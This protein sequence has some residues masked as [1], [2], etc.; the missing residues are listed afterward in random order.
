M[1]S[2]I[3]RVHSFRS[4]KGQSYHW[5]SRYSNEEI[6][7]SPQER[8]LELIQKILPSLTESDLS[9]NL[10]KEFSRSRGSLATSLLLRDDISSLL[11]PSKTTTTPSTS[12]LPSPSPSSLDITMDNKNKLKALDKAIQQWLSYSLSLDTLELRRITFD[13]SSGHILEKVARGESVHRVRSL[14]ELKRRLYDGKRCFALFHPALHEEPLVFI[15]VGLTTELSQS[16]ASLDITKS[17]KSPTHA[18]F[19][20]VNS[21]L[22][23]LRGLDMASLLIKEVANYLSIHFP[24]IVRFSTLSPIPKFLTWLDKKGK[25]VKSTHIIPSFFSQIDPFIPLLCEYI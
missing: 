7:T 25:E 23:A 16:L 2:L 19:Y 22:S 5:I 4:F 8:K 15:H 1:K 13:S 6:F 21:P 24:T 20:S 12:S 14:T 18:I 10:I 11:S 17:E 9:N 3:L